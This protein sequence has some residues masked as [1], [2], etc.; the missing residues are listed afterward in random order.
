MVIRVLLEKLF[1]WVQLALEYLELE[2]PGLSLE[3]VVLEL[4]LGLF[5]E[6][7]VLVLVSKLVLE[8]NC[9]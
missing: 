6:Q 7:V 3:L 8:H 9:C 5:L 2:V 4:V 1:D